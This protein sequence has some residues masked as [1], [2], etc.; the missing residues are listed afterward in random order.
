MSESAQSSQASPHTEA[1]D[2][3]L[4]IAENY[5]RVFVPAFFAQWAP[6]LC[7]AAGLSPG[8]RVLDVACGTG[9][10]ARTASP[11]VA[12]S[13]Q[14][15]GLDANEAM[16]T[17]A[18]RVAPEL[19]FQRGEAAALP[20]PDRSFD[21]V[22]CQMA[23]MF[24]ADRRAA[25]TEMSRV[26]RPGGVLALLV[27]GPLDDQPGFTPFVTVASR[28]AGPDA[29]GLLSSYFGCGD[30]AALAELLVDAGLADVR[31]EQRHGIYQAPSAEAMVRTEVESTPLIERIDESTYAAIRADAGAALQAFTTTD[32]RIE[33]PFSCLLAMGRR[34]HSSSGE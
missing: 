8:A 12:P 23:L 13:G 22:L 5:E 27:P 24:F 34:T 10:V 28:H 9:I 2:L 15:I 18:R 16:L 19:E 31:V 1:F 4:E 33:A 25:V 11:L 30:E 32:G 17:V 20:F 7:E 3:P 14:V 6:M 21:A 26:L 29:V